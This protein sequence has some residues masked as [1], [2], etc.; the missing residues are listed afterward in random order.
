MVSEL[1]RQFAKWDTLL[2]SSVIS[3]TR[4]R[5][6][7]KL[8]RWIS[9]SADGSAYPVILL[10]VA[11]ASSNHRMRSIIGSLASFAIEL[12]IYK[13]VKQRVRRTR[14]FE[15]IAGFERLAAPPDLFSFPS[16]HTAAAFVVAILMGN[17]FPLMLPVMCAWASLVGFSRVY[18]GVHYPTDVV[19][20]SILGI[21]SAKAGLVLTSIFL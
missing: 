20:G 6:L 7:N 5:R 1:A 10:I 2:F 4:T 13:L 19:A 17:S 8:L 9:K 3:R 12:P 18:L 15:R 16:G 11:L 14:P 21:A